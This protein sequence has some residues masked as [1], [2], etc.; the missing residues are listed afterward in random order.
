[1]KVWLLISAILVLGILGVHSV[2]VTIGSGTATNTTTGGP[3][4]YGTWYKNFREQYLLLASEIEDQGGGPGNINSVA[5]NV[6]ALNLCSPMPNYTIR[7]KHTSQTSLSATFEAGDYQT[8]FVENNF[9]PVVGW[10]THTFTTPFVWDG[11]SNILVDI[12]TS[13]IPGDYTQNASAY[14]TPTVFNSS[15]R[16]KSDTTEASTATTGVTSLNRSNIRFNMEAL[17]VTDPPNPAQIVS[18][19]DD[20]VN[21]MT[22]A[23]LNWASGG[24]APSGYKVHFGTTNPPPLTQ[25]TPETSFSP[26][27]ALHT[28]YFWKIIPYNAIG[29]AVNCP[30]W[31]FTTGGPVVTMTNGTQ[32][33]ADGMAYAFYDS[34]GPDGR[35]QNSE[36]YTFTFSATNPD[37]NI[38]LMFT[39]FNLESGWDVLNIYN[40][41]NASAP[42]IGPTEGYTGSTL[43][44]E[45]FGSNSVTFVFTS[46]SS[47]Q[48]DGWAAVITTDDTYYQGI[49]HQIEPI[50]I[51]MN[52]NYILENIGYYFFGYYLNYSISENQH[53]NWA[54]DG[55]DITLI[56]EP[57]WHGVEYIKVRATNAYGQFVEQTVKVTVLETDS[58]IEYFDHSGSMA[59]GWTTTH[60]GTTTY[61]WQ[62]YLV[63]EYDY[64]LKTMATFGGTTN[65]RLVSAIFDLSTYQ[66]IQVSFT[67][68]FLPFAGA[69]GTFAYTLNNLTY[70]TIETMDETFSGIKTYDLTALTGKPTVR[71]RWTYFND[72]Q[73]TGLENHWIIDNFS[74]YATVLDLD[75]P[76]PVAGFS[77]QSLGPGSATMQWVAS[78]DQYFGEYQIYF[79][80]D[81]QVTT[82]DQLWSA[83]NDP[84]LAN[85]QT[86]S[87]TLG[88]LT[89]GLYWAAIRAADQSDNYSSL[90]E[91]A[92]FFIDAIPPI[93]S[94]PIP[95]NQPLPNWC[96]ATTATIGCSIEDEH[97][98]VN[99]SSL[100]Y[101]LDANGNGVYDNDEEWTNASVRYMVPRN[102]NRDQI[103]FEI[104]LPD[105]GVVA[106]ELRVAD[107]H[108]NTSY[109]GFQGIQGITDDWVVRVDAIPPAEMSDFFVDSIGDNSVQ[110]SWAASSDLNFSGYRIYYGDDPGITT[111][112]A[113]WD[114]NADPVMQLPGSGFVSTT[115]T[116]LIPS[117]RYYFRLFATDEAGW[118]TAFPEEITSMTSATDAPLAPQNL[119]LSIQGDQLVIDWADVNTDIFGN[120][121]GI[122]YYEV[123]VGD[124]PYFV[125]DNESLLTTVS[126]SSLT[127]EGVI[128][129]ADRL[130]FKIVA[131]SGSIRSHAPAIK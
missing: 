38:Y 104:E 91:P 59:P 129:Y 43:P 2:I 55:D 95:G 80:T 21:V 34:G 70:V 12:Y 46:D 122:S 57:D 125:C 13:L 99:L 50:L 7:L 49:L 84:L 100:H 64:G 120:P 30:V 52:N 124:Q 39:D 113:L 86:V 114:F 110:L 121:I 31:S 42:Q 123:Y 92:G 48:D 63:G 15:L 116:G 16:Y 111:E 83:V 8:V 68:D 82:T 32:S 56:P 62:P 45:I 93:L 36:N 78:S 10:N 73:N 23:T 90:S 98:T 119:I 22:S 74:I 18:P 79:S 14:Y 27:L 3:A 108:G 88:P 128:A 61:P 19:A 11:T 67:T 51:L 103:A 37:S 44:E 130:F 20:A 94:A 1:M 24:G 47:G 102:K 6:A 101:R 26:N 9:L 54:I 5:F 75:P 127:L 33:V 40:G 69:S 109:S 71:F 53:I 72:T 107:T 77:V 89:T 25:N 81:D 17:V 131:V 58:I 105:N 97:S 65:E 35:Y 126:V 106:W 41:P 28:K 85:V 115:I 118:V 66:D 96:T 4:P 60:S 117:T 87:T 29:D 112:D 76:E